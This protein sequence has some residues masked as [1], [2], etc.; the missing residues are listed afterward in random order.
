LAAAASQA[1]HRFRFAAQLAFAAVA[2]PAAAQTSGL[3]YD[4]QPPPNS[5]YVRVINAAPDAT[6][7]VSVDGRARLSGLATGD[8]SDYLVLPAGKR[9]L[10]IAARGNPAPA[11]VAVDVVAGRALTIAFHSVRAG[12]QPWIFEDKAN[13]NKLK[14]VVAVYNLVEKGSA[15]DVLTADGATKVFSSVAPGSSSGLSVNPIKVELV[16]TASGTT[17]PLARAALSMAPGGTY[18]MLFFRSA[19]GELAARA[20]HNK[21]ERYTGKPAAS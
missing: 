13:T 16:T 11:D 19:R 14:A 8:A 4:P 15:I 1:L 10:S 17:A 6:V 9:V 7:D 12:S 21:V 20:L 5:A 18:S 3:L 2:M